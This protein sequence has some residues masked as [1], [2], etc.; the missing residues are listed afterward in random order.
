VTILHAG[1]DQTG[2][3]RGRTVDL[4]VLIYFRSTA[5]VNAL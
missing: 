3:V 4:L 1:L 2:K 5:F